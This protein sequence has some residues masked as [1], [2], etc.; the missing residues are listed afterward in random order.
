MDKKTKIIVFA[1][2]GVAVLGAASYGFNQWRRQRL[3][4]QILNAAYSGNVAGLL[5]NREVAQEIAQQI[6]NQE[7]EEKSEEA[8]EAAKTPEDRYNETQETAII[9]SISPIVGATIKPAME[10]VFGKVK[11]TSYGTGYMV[12]Q[13]GSFGATFKTPRVVTAQDL[14]ALTEKLEKDGYSV[15][16]SEVQSDSGSVTLAKGQ[17][18]MLTVAYSDGGEDQEVEVTYL[19]MTDQNEGTQNDETEE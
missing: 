10:A 9:G 1:V 12:L 3:A 17:S 8:R 4:A 2:I 19:D 14:S 6:A 18:I 5:N 16:N 11:L 7:A 13:N 15:M